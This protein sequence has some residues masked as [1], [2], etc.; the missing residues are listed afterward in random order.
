MF[1][2]AC[3]GSFLGAHASRW[4]GQGTGPPE[5]DLSLYR[6]E[7]VCGGGGDGAGAG[8]TGQVVLMAEGDGGSGS[9]PGLELI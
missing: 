7:G 2:Q 4:L 5:L 8:D 3:L 1:L 9:K 6:T